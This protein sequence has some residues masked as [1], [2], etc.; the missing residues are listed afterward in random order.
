MRFRQYLLAHDCPQC[1]A[2]DAQDAWGGAR[3][4]SST[5]GHSFACCSDECGLK[6]AKTVIP[7]QQTKAGRK[8]LKK[9]WEKLG[10]QAQYRLSGEPYPGY[11]W[12]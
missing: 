12:R 8:R 4:T 9:L 11:P 10:G 5:W 6:L 7:D 1:G 3:M 2:K